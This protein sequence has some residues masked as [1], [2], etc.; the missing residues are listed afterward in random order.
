MLLLTIATMRMAFRR[1]DPFR[2]PGRSLARAMHARSDADFSAEMLSDLLL[3]PCRKKGNEQRQQCGP[4]TTVPYTMHRFCFP[5]WGIWR[6]TGRSS[7]SEMSRDSGSK[8]WR[9]T[10]SNI[11][12][13]SE[14]Y[15]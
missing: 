5:I 6:H 14:F 11:C 4:C 2:L 12:A 9:L 7:M 3:G 1:R 10:P 8:N 13:V 15:C